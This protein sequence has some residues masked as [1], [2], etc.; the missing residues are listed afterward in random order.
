M[1][2]RDIGELI[3][4]SAE[5]LANLGVESL[6][7]ARETTGACW[8]NAFRFFTDSQGP[9]GPLPQP[10]FTLG[11][12]EEAFNE[13]QLQK[14]QPLIGDAL[15][16]SSFFLAT[17]NMFLLFLTSEIDCEALN[18]A[19][20]RYAYSQ[21]VALRG[22][23]NLFRLLGQENELHREINGFS[24]SHNSDHVRIY[25]HYAVIDGE[26]FK[27]YRCR[28]TDFHISPTMEGDHRWKAYAFARN[29][30]NLWL[31]DHF[32]RICSAIDQLPDTWDFAAFDQSRSQNLDSEP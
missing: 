2:K 25:G 5:K 18:I 15:E 32:K 22:L 26:N 7:I 9:Q 8:A 17:Y 27:F 19:D 31:P 1:A 29:V 10:D 16:D 24:I 23:A 28:I 30:Y 21:S 12:K 14:L 20:R 13:N 6:E 4:P 3:V 11:F